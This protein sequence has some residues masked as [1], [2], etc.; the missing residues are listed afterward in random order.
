[1]PDQVLKITQA[2]LSNP[3]KILVKS[4]NVTLEGIAQYYM[5]CVD[6]EAKFSAL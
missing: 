3:V 4:E 1:M 5:S 2:A 6:E